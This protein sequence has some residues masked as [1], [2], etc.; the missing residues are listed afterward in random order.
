MQF[1]SKAFYTYSFLLCFLFAILIKFSR[2]DLYGI[3]LT[4]DV[5]L[6]SLPSFLYL[7][8]IIS[9]IPVF[10]KKL[11]FESYKKFALGLTV[12]ALVYELEQYWTSRVFDVNDIIA[13]LIAFSLITVLHRL[14]VFKT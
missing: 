11:K 3:T 7:F 10:Y 4:L 12:G 9:A 14:N 8:G 13:T 5:L 6:G 1:K 2:A